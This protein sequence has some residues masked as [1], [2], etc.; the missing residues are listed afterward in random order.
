MD[1][2]L[3]TGQYIVQVLNDNEDL[4]TLLGEGKIFPLIAKTD[5]TYPFIIYE[6]SAITPIYTK[7]FGQDN[8]VQITFRIYAEEYDQGLQITNLV[9][10]ILERQTINFPNIIRINDIRLGSTNEQFTDDAFLQT[11]TFTTQVE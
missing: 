11:L 1:N 8:N 5:T 7:T 3:L 10:N 9:R 2:S 4:T 6:R